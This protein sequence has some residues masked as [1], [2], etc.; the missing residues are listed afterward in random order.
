MNN[1]KINT[2]GNIIKYVKT[3]NVKIK[4]KLRNY[5]KSRNEV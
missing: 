2:I 1:F 4:L 5:R 3:D